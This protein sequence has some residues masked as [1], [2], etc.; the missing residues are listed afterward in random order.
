MRTTRQVVLAVT[1]AG[2]LTLSACGGGSTGSGGDSIEISVFAG[3]LPEASP[4]GAGV[5]AMVDHINEAEA[6]LE[7]IAFFDTALGDASTMVQ[8]MQ[9]GTIDVG[10][11]G[12]A[13]YSSL[14]PEIQAFELPFLFE[15]VEEARSV[16]GEGAVRDEMFTYFDETDVVGLSIWEGACASSATTPA[17]SPR[18]T[19]SPG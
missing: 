5:T 13:Y 12:N 9:E 15:S 14:V 19:T 18:P 2:A 8:G 17:P 6:G 3:S 1:A 16:T 4:Q 11:S 7:A 10:V